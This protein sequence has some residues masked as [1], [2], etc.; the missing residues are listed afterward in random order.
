MPGTS[1]EARPGAGSAPRVSRL[2]PRADKSEIRNSKS[3][4]RP[5]IAPKRGHIVASSPSAPSRR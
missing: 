2:L 1:E 3:P 4:A 5:V